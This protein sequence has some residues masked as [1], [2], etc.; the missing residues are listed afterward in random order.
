SLV[1][2]WLRLH[3]PNTGGLGLI[4]GQ[5]TRSHMHA[6]TKSLHATTKDPTCCN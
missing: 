4:P 1:A 5:G 3:A 6:A 2:Q